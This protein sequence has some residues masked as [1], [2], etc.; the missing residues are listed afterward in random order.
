MLKSN[1]QIKAESQKSIDIALDLVTTSIHS[2]E[3]LTHIQLELSRQILMETTHVFKDLSVGSDS[4]EISARLNTVVTK[5]VEKN[6]ASVRDVLDV[7]SETQTKI[8][9]ITEGNLQHIQQSALN[10]VESLA[11]YNPSGAEAVGE[12]VKSW[13]QNSNQMLA[14]LNKVSAQVSEFAN[15][16]INT[17]TDAALKAAK[18]ANAK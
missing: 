6:I 16:N 4:K 7:V 14:A 17:A 3:K 18:K 1:D 15:N 13:I 5:A 9:Q 8:S 2:V 12:S 10:S 11:K